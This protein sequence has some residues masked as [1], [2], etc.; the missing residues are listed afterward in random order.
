MPGAALPLQ[1]AAMNK[2]N[3]QNGSAP[4]VSTLHK[5]SSCG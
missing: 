2:P 3:A 1:W 5:A 4:R